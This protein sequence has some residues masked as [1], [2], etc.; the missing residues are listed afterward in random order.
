[1]SET[2]S[3]TFRVYNS[4]SGGAPLWTSASLTVNID[5]GFFSVGVP[6][7]V[8]ALG[9]GGARYLEVTAGT[10]LLSPRALLASVPYAL[11]ARTIEGTLD[12][13]GAGLSVSS[14]PSA[15][16]ALYVSSQTGRVGVGTTAP[17]YPLDVLG[18]IRS[19]GAVS[20]ARWEAGLATL[21]GSTFTVGATALT[22][23]TPGVGIG[24]A[25]PDQRLTVAGNVSMTGT[26]FSSGTAASAFLGS[27]GIGTSAPPARL[28]VDEGDIRIAT[29]VAAA[30]GIYF[31]D[32]S[33]MTKA[34]VGSYA[35]LSNAGDL[36]IQGDSDFS[37]Q[38][39]VF[40]RTGGQDR[41]AVANDGKVGLGTVLPGFG[42]DVAGAGQ[43]GA[44]ANRSTFTAE[45]ALQLT[46]GAT[47]AASGTLSLSTAGTASLTGVPA[48]FLDPQGRTGVGMAAPA[49]TLHS[50]GD[51]RS[52]GDLVVWPGTAAARALSASLLELGSRGGFDLQLLSNSAVPRV[53][54]PR[55]G[56]VGI[57]TATVGGLLRVG[58]G[59]TSFLAVDAE[60][61]VG[62]GVSSPTAHLQVDGAVTIDGTGAGMNISSGALTVS[63]SNVGLGVAVPQALFQIGSSA[64]AVLGE[65]K[66]GIGT[67]SPAA[68][69]DV[70]GDAVFGIVTRSTF[71]AGGDLK[72][73]G[74]FSA[75]TF[76]GLPVIVT[77]LSTPLTLEG[78]PSLSTQRTGI[79]VST[80]FF[81]SAGRL[82]VGT[83]SPAS[84]LHL[85]SG[86]LL[87]DGDI[88][89][90]RVGLST[91]VV[92]Q[93]NVGV[94][95]Q[96]PA[97]RLHLSSGT[98][99]I[100]GTDPFLRVGEGKFQAAAG[101]IGFGASL[102]GSLVHVSSGVLIVDGTSPGLTV[103]VSTL[104]VSGGLT[105]VGT[106]SPGAVL[107]VEGAARFGSGATRST[108]TAAGELQL[109]AGATVSAGGTLSFSTAAS[110][111]LTGS[112]ALFFDR[113]GRAGLGTAAPNSALTVGPAPAGSWAASS[114]AVH[115]GALAAG[116]G[117]EVALANFGFSAGGNAASLGLRAHR[118]AGAPN[119]WTT[120]AVGL[121]YDVDNTP[122]AGAALWLHANG[123]VGVGTT[124]PQ[125][126][127][128]VVDGDIR[129]STIAAA[130]G[131]VFRD[132][133]RQITAETSANTVWE[134]L[135]ANIYNTNFGRLGLGVVTP[136]AFLDV[137]GRIRIHPDATLS[138]VPPSFP[139]RLD[140][141][142]ASV[143]GNCPRFSSYLYFEENSQSWLYGANSRA[144]FLWG[145]CDD[146]VWTLWSAPVSGG[147]GAGSS[148]A[149][150]PR[151][152]VT[153]AGRVGIGSTA[154]DANLVVEDGAGPALRLRRDGTN[155][156]FLAATPAGSNRLGFR[157]LVNSSANEALT[158][159]TDGR[160]GI[161]V[162]APL[163]GLDN[164]LGMAVGTYAGNNAA[165]AGG[166]IVS[167][168][169]GI[170]RTDPSALVDVAGVTARG[171]RYTRTA[172]GPVRMDV[173][174]PGGSWSLGV[175]Y[176]G[177]P[178]RFSIMQGGTNR[179]TITNTGNVGIGTD[180]PLNILD[181]AAPGKMA[182]G[183][184]AGTAP[185][186][187]DDSLIVGGKIGIGITA[188]LSEVQVNGQ[189]VTSYEIS[190]GVRGLRL[191]GKGRPGGLTY[192]GG[193]PCTGGAGGVEARLSRVQVRWE[194]VTDA[195]PLGTW[196]CTGSERGAAACDTGR[197]NTVCDGRYSMG[198][199]V[200][201]NAN[202][203]LGW[204][205][206]LWTDGLS[207]SGLAIDELGVSSVTVVGAHELPTW[208]CN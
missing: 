66:V 94:G 166:L 113:S 206:D 78:T 34:G 64:L 69:L 186:E 128:H 123:N 67:S 156:W 86:T 65:G 24:T 87:I 170:G 140:V 119:D 60:G 181:I 134:V 203:H 50:A 173:T 157:P 164:P 132:G 77:A 172:A 8:A 80:H 48:L 90:I 58:A 129:I 16:S 37:G 20:S 120:T 53:Y 76:N 118:T 177:V 200:N 159:L 189:I 114:L 28:T 27:A 135:G 15:G 167:G 199:C 63:G 109:V 95:A 198:G 185:P 46:A 153:A 6:I 7:P 150:A 83:T 115:A 110:V 138:A 101:R 56:G 184:F 84:A 32:G 41:L 88:P 44:G 57:A 81:V 39:M 36:L 25:S 3:L 49:A 103:G 40:L 108:I 169:L 61:D 126:R 190:P 79:E 55:S 31:P 30:R 165:P 194:H 29:T 35:G 152:T 23:A 92:A 54:L 182:M 143:V 4:A 174:E 74:N 42:L 12:I 178:G 155:D 180:T 208:C 62:F 125:S 183:T 89:G 18:D 21:T 105:G 51:I 193:A 133:S 131:I 82:G 124:L 96:N 73:T 130:R 22:V 111:A 195:C 1:M 85:S 2:R 201:L 47:V 142:L 117:S 26:L 196:V 144:G 19:T 171:I 93:G 192:A 139:A 97:T 11:V 191:Y 116:A 147:A 161:G 43:F 75:A 197:P 71:T 9:G 205:L 33:F 207:S 176:G 13:S 70:A 38:G 175:G 148:A 121:S 100:D 127:L 141:G 98:M 45:G 17:A 163:G 137:L 102:P 122:R 151:L 162:T 204:V 136:S 146:D 107:D 187:G 68:A 158:I 154:P 106:A 202:A 149:V 52:D 188:P 5:R 91:F 145:G 10:V 99:L 160:A 59:G 72:I 168:I 179:V 112:P 104:T 14:V